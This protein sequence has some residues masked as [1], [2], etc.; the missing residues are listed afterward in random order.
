MALKPILLLHDQWSLEDSTYLMQCSIDVM[1]FL[2]A[3][4]FPLSCTNRHWNALF[5]FD[6]GKVA[7]A[8]VQKRQKTDRE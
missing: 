5:F 7:S 3:S 2:N 8:V 6:K 4:E 1:A